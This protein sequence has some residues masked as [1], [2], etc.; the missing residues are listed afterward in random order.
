MKTS[1]TAFFSNLQEQIASAFETDPIDPCPLPLSRSSVATEQKEVGGLTT[2]FSFI[3]Q[4]LAEIHNK[5]E[6]EKSKL[7][8]IIDEKNNEISKLQSTLGEFKARLESIQHS[9]EIL[10]ESV[11]SLKVQL[12]TANEATK[13]VEE[14]RKQIIELEDNKKMLEED[15]TFQ[16][17]EITEYSD[18]Q[19]RFEIQI[20]ELKRKNEEKDLKNDCLRDEIQT[21]QEEK[22]YLEKHI[23]DLSSELDSAKALGR[24]RVKQ[25]EEEE[26]KESLAS[27]SSI[28]KMKDALKAKEQELTM[29][30]RKLRDHKDI[31]TTKHKELDKEREELED[32]RSQAEQKLIEVREMRSEAKKEMDRIREMRTKQEE[33]DRRRK[34]EKAVEE[35]EEA[36]RTVAVSSSSRT[37]G[38][39]GVLGKRRSLQEQQAQRKVLHVVMNPTAEARQNITQEL[40]TLRKEN[41][42]LKKQVEM[43]QSRAIQALTPAIVKRTPLAVVST[44]LPQSTPEQQEATRLIID[45]LS[46]K[47]R[48]LNRKVRKQSDQLQ[49]SETFL[50]DYK[51][52]MSEVIEEYRSCVTW[53]TGWQLRIDS[54]NKGIVIAKHRASELSRSFDESDYQVRFKIMDAIT[55]KF[56]LMDSEIV[57]KYPSFIKKYLEDKSSYSA[58]LAALLLK[59]ESNL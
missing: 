14:Y 12:K 11:S 33:E 17:Q 38:S 5:R 40:D 48:Y 58:Y 54:E 13:Q 23:T 9:N 6:I 4:E 34:E 22:T 39:I 10:E 52:K 15:I 31:L 25:L 47:M 45:D 20:D 18:S 1:S 8:R 53:L 35:E 55:G 28:I 2:D 37:S 26:K 21:L 56:D 32:L 49:T 3:D 51:K 57:R 7:Q 46:K 27:Q 41:Q 24:R 50:R 43:Y 16:Q 29:E 30:L 59:I 44:T 19:K 42:E 36:D